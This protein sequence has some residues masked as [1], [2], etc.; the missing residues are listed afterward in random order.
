VLTT[1]CRAVAG[2]LT[3]F[4]LEVFPK[5]TEL[6]GKGLGNL[7][8]LPLGI[9]RLSGKRS[10][11]IGCADRAPQAQLAFLAK[12]VPTPLDRLKPGADPKAQVVVHPRVAAYAAQFPELVELEQRCAPLGQIIAACRAGQK[13]NLREEKIIYQTIGLLP[14]AKLLLHHLE[15]FDGDYNPHLVDF[16]LSRLKGTPLGCRRIH[17]LL[18]YEAPICFNAAGQAYAHPLLHL[19]QWREGETQRA[20]KIDNLEEALNNLQAAMDQVRRFLPAPHPP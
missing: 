11:F 4:S 16:K 19:A 17:S 15:G 9:H 14:R 20:E 13:M 6:S 10:V 5:Q 7:V 18:Q 2:D 3:A 8:K 12:V 1:I